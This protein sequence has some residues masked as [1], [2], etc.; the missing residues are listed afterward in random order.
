MGPGGALAPFALYLGP[1]LMR[2]VGFCR[3][4]HIVLELDGGQ[5]IS[6]DLETQEIKDF[7]IIGYN[8]VDAYVESLVL[9]DKTANN[10]I[11]Y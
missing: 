10:A 2:A 5:L 3:S 11:T 4:G 7:G 8:F 1:S 6:W 9:L